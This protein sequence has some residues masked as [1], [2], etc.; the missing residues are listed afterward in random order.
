MKRRDFLHFLHGTSWTTIFWSFGGLEQQNQVTAA[1]EL[2]KNVD[3]Q[4]RRDSFSSLRS[5]HRWQNTAVPTAQKFA[6][7]VGLNHYADSTIAP[8]AGCLTDLELQRQLLCHRYGFAPKNILT[9]ADQQATVSNF[10]AALTQYL[11]NQ[12]QPGDVVVFHFSGYGMLLEGK[13]ALGLFDK[14]FPLEAWQEWL[15]SLPTPY[16]TTILD[17]SFTPRLPS[18]SSNLNSRSLPN[19]SPS[20]EQEIFP[21]LPGVTIRATAPG[22]EAREKSWGDFSAGLFTYSFTQKLWQ[23]NS[24]LLAPNL[25][26]INSSLK[27]RDLQSPSYILGQR[28]NTPLFFLP[29]DLLPLAHGSVLKVAD[30]ADNNIFTLWLGGL[31]PQVL[32]YSLNSLLSTSNSLLL[33]I[34]EHSGLQAKAKVISLEN[35]TLNSLNTSP[36]SRKLSPVGSLLKELVRVIPQNVSLQIAFDRQLSRIERVDATSAFANIS[37]IS[38]GKETADY[39]FTLQDGSYGL[40]TLEGDLL[41]KTQGLPGEA[42]KSAVNR[43]KHLLQNLL[44]IKLLYLSENPG[45]IFN[46]NHLDN[47]PNPQSP[48]I[49]QPSI[50]ITQDSDNSRQ[51]LLENQS[52]RP[53]SGLIFC[54]TP[55]QQLWVIGSNSSQGILPQEISPNSNLSIAIP[56]ELINPENTTGYNIYGI[57]S[58]RSLTH[59]LDILKTQSSES[60]STALK[61]SAPL[62]VVQALYQDL[63][64][65]D[66]NA[67]PI[68]SSDNYILEVN[69][70]VT[71]WL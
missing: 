31:P 55:D 27:N 29:P 67:L 47:S 42:A 44:A 70:W 24:T 62:A 33:Q 4:L 23:T 57:F 40:S 25:E 22:Q 48:Q 15:R 18:A 21:S 59:T 52:G 64:T 11:G 54:A 61:L 14:C 51:Y 66:S 60:K 56:R 13:A 63:Q 16:I 39:L 69:S 45:N 46:P 5:P 50:Q 68:N 8:L 65:P 26:L 34:I 49:I 12:V 2:P 35:L 30:E 6:L 7:L 3:S 19:T 28:A 20:P 41:C 37:G 71:F 1:L 58:S 53:L 43:L 17:T 32:A 36:T 9:L 38:L 10:Q